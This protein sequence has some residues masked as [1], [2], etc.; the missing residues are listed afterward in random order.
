M[1]PNNEQ[2]GWPR[3]WLASV[4]CARTSPH[5]RTTSQL[6]RAIHETIAGGSVID[7][8]V[9][10][11]LVQRT[12]MPAMASLYR[13]TPRELDVLRQMAQGRSN[14]AIAAAMNLSESAVEKQIGSIFLKLDL[15]PEPGH[16]SPRRRG[17]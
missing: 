10:D 17:S 8:E 6:L 4:P 14:T 13:L 16:P 11:G 1:T 12:A 5:S 2:H 3:T 7:P 15:A 9:V